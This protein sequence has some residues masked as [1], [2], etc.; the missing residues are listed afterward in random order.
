MNKNLD[1]LEEAV[2]VSDLASSVLGFTSISF[3]LEGQGEEDDW[4]DND[5]ESG[6]E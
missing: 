3:V 5:E 4:S 2:F 6:L 1:E